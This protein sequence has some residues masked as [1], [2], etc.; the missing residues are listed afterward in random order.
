MARRTHYRKLGELVATTRQLGRVSFVRL[1]Q[2][3]IQLTRRHESWPG[4]HV[5][6]SDDANQQYPAVVQR[7]DPVQRIVDIR[8][9]GTEQIESVSVLEV[10]HNSETEDD[11]GVTLGE[12][13]FI[14]N[15]SG[16]PMPHVP[17]IGL[18][19]VASMNALA[20]VSA[21]ERQSDL[22]ERV[23]SWS[24]TYVESNDID[25]IGE[26]VSLELDGRLGVRLANGDTVT[27]ELKN[28]LLLKPMEEGDMMD[29]DS[30]SG[31]S[32]ETDYGDAMR[33][34]P[35]F[36]GSISALTN[37]V[38]ANARRQRQTREADD[39]ASDASW[40]TAYSEEDLQ[41]SAMS[42]PMTPDTPHR[43]AIP[44]IDAVSAVHHNHEAQSLPSSMDLDG[45]S[46]DADWVDE[47][48][49]MAPSSPPIRESRSP[50]LPLMTSHESNAEA[51]PSSVS[52]TITW[53]SFVVLD[54]APSDHQFFRET[55]ASSSRARM[56]K[57][58]AEHKALRTSLPGKN[59]HK[60]MIRLI[61]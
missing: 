29:E 26:V 24:N 15:D 18:T 55:P 13:V 51:G 6:W 33:L 28:V 8:L 46:D 41:D 9:S 40:E 25:W 49:E 43:Q 34:G 47:S 38:L 5:I 10:E 37:I 16:S 36:S 4:Q 31:R 42:A 19:P 39:G 61:L 56:K 60:Q 52:R 3:M 11:Y 35:T 53:D 27:L 48:I 32:S 14:C 2:R 17:A 30:D 54:S 57:I 12:Y 58:N 23:H 22:V 20:V 7:Y 21:L 50:S 44:H 45:N 1:H 59:C